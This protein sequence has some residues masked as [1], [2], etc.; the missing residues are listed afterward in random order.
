[1]ALRR[2]RAVASWENH[3]HGVGVGW[4]NGMA[5]SVRGVAGVVTAIVSDGPAFV[6]HPTIDSVPRTKQIAE[7]AALGRGENEGRAATCRDRTRPR[8]V[9]SSGRPRPPNGLAPR[10][11]DPRLGG[12]PRAAPRRR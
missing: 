11:D 7:S 12:A 1:M 10:A 2:S 5:E 6:Y 8:R 9:V 4:E 3:W